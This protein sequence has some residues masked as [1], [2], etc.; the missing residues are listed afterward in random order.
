MKTESLMLAHASRHNV[1]KTKGGNEA[2]VYNFNAG[3]DAQWLGAYFNG[4]EWIPCKWD[5]F[6]KFPSINKKMQS[7]KLDLMMPNAA[8]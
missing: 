7:T 8:V 1:F 3:G 6:G 4:E 2:I 5:H